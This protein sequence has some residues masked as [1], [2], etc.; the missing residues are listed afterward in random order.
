M[1]E[2]VDYEKSAGAGWLIP[3]YLFAI[4]GGLIGIFIGVHL[5]SGKITLPD[6]T[7]VK[8]FNQSSRTQ[9]TIMLIIGIIAI[10]GWRV[11]A[12]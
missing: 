6:G 11:A 5:M 4:L 8:K 7:K 12:S 1:Q 3:G 10:I 2:G 9:G